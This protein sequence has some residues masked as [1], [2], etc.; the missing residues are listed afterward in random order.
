MQEWRPQ[1]YRSIG[2]QQGVDPQVLRHAVATGEQIIAIHSSLPPVFTL[3]HLAHLTDVEYGFLRAVVTRDLCDPY[4]IFRIPKSDDEAHARGFRIICIPDPSLMRVQRWIAHHIL[5]FGRSHPACFA[6]AKGSDIKNAAMVH[7]G[8]RWLIKLDVRSFFE[9]ISEIA[10]YR[11]FSALGYQPLVAF[12]LARICTRVGRWTQA[13]GHK[14]WLADRHQHRTIPAYGHQRIGHLPQGAPTSPMLSNIAMKAFDEAVSTIAEHHNLLYTRYADDLCLST[15]N[16]L[17][18]R[19]QAARVV[20]QVY[21]AMGRM[22]LSPNVT[23]TRVSPPGSRK[24]VLGLLVD[25]KEPCLTREF[26][27]RLRQHIYYLLH[28]EIGPARHAAKRGFVSVH[29]L[30]NHVEGL[31]AFARHVDPDYAQRCSQRLSQVAWPL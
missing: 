17:F 15:T 30:R 14:R 25:G 23:K 27:A 10:A 9:S 8:C 5:A 29:G 4:R 21:V 2:Q 7:C 22:G 19:G 12:E 6:Y 24:V 18:T 28:P 26:R 13:Q 20:R 16:Q 1:H 31:V 11:V 3:R